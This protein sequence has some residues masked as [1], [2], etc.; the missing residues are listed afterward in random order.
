MVITQLQPVEVLD[1][2]RR[3][4]H[5]PTS[6]GTL[7]DDRLV[8]ALLRRSAGTHCPCSRAKLRSSLVESLHCL[9]DDESLLS[10]R[11]DEIIDALVVTGDLLE[12]SDVVTDDPGA[13]GTWVYAG[14][15]A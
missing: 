6:P 9:S 15:P 14:P 2:C 13:R 1:C 11:I 8:A 7:I 12:L 10:G 5:L 4:L 3:S